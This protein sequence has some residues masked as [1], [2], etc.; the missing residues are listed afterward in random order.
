MTGFHALV[1]ND[2]LH[3]S[4]SIISMTVKIL[5]MV[6]PTWCRACLSIIRIGLSHHCHRTCITVMWFLL[7]HLVVCCYVSPL[8]TA[9]VDA[10]GCTSTLSI[11]ADWLTGCACLMPWSWVFSIGEWLIDVSCDSLLTWYFVSHD[12]LVLYLLQLTL[13]SYCTTIPNSYC[14]RFAVL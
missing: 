14:T 12:R 8:A 6:G 7:T 2:N 5:S 9:F 11:V 1:A 10:C 3:V 4:V 13:I